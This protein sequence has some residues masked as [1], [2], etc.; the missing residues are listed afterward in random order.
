MNNILNVFE[1]HSE[2][3]LERDFE[4][5][6]VSISLL[7]I[8]KSRAVFG[9]I[10]SWIYHHL[11]KKL[12]IIL[13]FSSNEFQRQKKLFFIHRYFKSFLRKYT[14]RAL[15]FSWSNFDKAKF[16][17][18]G[19]FLRKNGLIWNKLFATWAFKLGSLWYLISQF[20]FLLN[21]DDQ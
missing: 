15:A 11:E 12:H 21:F 13:F 2:F 5:C 7:G 9:K 1:A 14:S 18:K 19:E 4:S 10:L 16:P 17:K 3:R 20:S 6:Q 8:L